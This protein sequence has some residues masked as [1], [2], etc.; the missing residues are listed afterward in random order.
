VGLTLDECR[1]LKFKKDKKFL[2][3]WCHGKVIV[4]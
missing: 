4:S 1:H 2:T 3:S